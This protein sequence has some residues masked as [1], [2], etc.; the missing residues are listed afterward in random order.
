MSW[1]LAFAMAG[2]VE[3]ALPPTPSWW[4]DPAS[5]PQWTT[6]LSRQIALACEATGHACDVTTSDKAARRLVLQCADADHWTLEAHDV[7]GTGLWHIEVRG[8]DDE[9]L[10]AAAVWVARS[11]VTMAAAPTTT[12]ATPAAPPQI[13]LNPPPQQRWGGL[14]L[15]GRLGYYA[16]SGDGAPGYGAALRIHDPGELIRFLPPRFNSFASLAGEA[17]WSG[18]YFDERAF[19]LRAGVGITWHAPRTKDIIGFSLEL[20]VGVAR[21]RE[22]NPGFSGSDRDPSRDYVITGHVPFG[23]LLARM[24]AEAP[25]PGIFRPFISLGLGT[26]VPKSP[27][28][29]MGSVE[30]GVRWIAW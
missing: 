26:T 22:T 30:I 17:T 18:G 29:V 1:A 3:A 4:V 9:R 20:G 11:D 23:Y 19:S 5:C 28:L 21:T 24:I 27:G 15:A 13:T 16:D 25:V 6:P 7:S 14:D 12:P 2:A 8:G 10:R